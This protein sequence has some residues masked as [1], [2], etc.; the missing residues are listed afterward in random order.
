MKKKEMLEGLRKNRAS[1]ITSMFTSI[2]S[3]EWG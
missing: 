1:S 2:Y 3:A